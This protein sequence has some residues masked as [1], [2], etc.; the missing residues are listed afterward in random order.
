MNVWTL[1][2]SMIFRGDSTRTALH[3]IQ[4]WV[5]GYRWIDILFTCRYERY[6]SDVKDFRQ[7]CHL[8]DVTLEGTYHHQLG[9]TSSAQVEDKLYGQLSH[10]QVVQLAQMYFIDLVMFGYNV[11]R[12]LQFA[13][14]D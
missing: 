6:K 3:H 14:P 12:Y 8:E 10:N 7:E 4:E 13:R 2:V 11:S 9:N 5:T 1:A